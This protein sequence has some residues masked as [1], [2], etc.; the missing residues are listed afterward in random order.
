[1]LKGTIVELTG[2]QSTSTI[3]TF[4]DKDIVEICLLQVGFYAQTYLKANP[5]ATEEDVMEHICDNSAQIIIDILEQSDECI[6]R[7]L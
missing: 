2:K 4:Y 3:K 6:I 1:M 7:E 5:K